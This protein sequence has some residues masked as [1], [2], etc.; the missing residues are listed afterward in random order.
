MNIRERK[1]DLKTKSIR[2]ISF[3]RAVHNGAGQ[4]CHKASFTDVAKSFL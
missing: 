2:V 3:K 4:S 1:G